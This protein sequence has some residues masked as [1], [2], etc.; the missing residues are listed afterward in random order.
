LGSLRIPLRHGTR[1]AL[2]GVGWGA[3]TLLA[4]LAITKAKKWVS[5]PAWGWEQASIDEVLRSAARLSVGHLAVA[6]NEAMVFRGDGFETVREA[7]GQGKAV[8]LLIPGF[9][10]YHGLA[11]QQV[12]G[13][14]AGGPTLMLL[15]R[16]HS[17][18]LWLPV[19]YHRLLKNTLVLPVRCTNARV[20]HDRR[21]A[22]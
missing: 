13:I 21:S 18:T 10:L 6:W 1:Q 19:G 2:Q 7:L 12:L 8:T 4:W 5:A 15:R 16:L 11:L 9:A 3:G 17:N 22:I 14:L 20:E